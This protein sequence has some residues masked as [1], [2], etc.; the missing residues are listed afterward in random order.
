MSL[1]IL[2]LGTGVCANSYGCKK[3]RKPQSYLIEVDGVMILFE[4]PEG[5]RLRLEDYGYDYG[6]V[7]HVAV[8]HG[9]PDHACL[10]QFLQSKSCR[11]IFGD[12]DHPEFGLCTVYLP[13]KLV[14]GFQKV[15]DWHHPE[16]DG[17]YWPEFTPRFV[18]MGE[19]SAVGIAPN[20]TLKSF[21]VFHGYGKHPC[22]AYRLET[23]YGVVA[24]SG[25]SAVCDGLLAAAKQADLFICEQAWNIGYKDKVHYGHLT[26]VEVGEVCAKAR[27]KRVRLTHYIGL[28]K[29][30][31][32]IA[33]IRRGGFKGD[34]K[35]AKDGDRWEL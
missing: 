13:T 18:S 28:D 10:P 23:P 33:E 15:W 2:A 31:D 17:K 1:K 22:V 32:V 25:D 8:S 29:D 24:Y 16:N 4:C 6:Y 34:A 35:R 27:V 7:Q 19:G 11:R 5:V 21:P 30:A 20:I 3:E 26:P 14:E 12:D 9:H